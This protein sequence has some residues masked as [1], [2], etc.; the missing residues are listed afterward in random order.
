MSSVAATKPPSFIEI[1]AGLL[2]GIDNK[3]ENG[4]LVTFFVSDR[5]DMC[6]AQ[7]HIAES[8][9]LDNVINQD[10]YGELKLDYDTTGEKRQ[11]LREFRNHVVGLQKIAFVLYPLSDTTLVPHPWVEMESDI[12][13]YIYPGVRGHV[14][15]R[16]KCRRAF[17]KV[18]GHKTLLLI[19]S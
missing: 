2:P 11:A 4:C 7:K 3:I 5:T 17:T 8:L 16:G 14:I 1:P 13:F 9:G 12:S 18:N 6:Y 10:G 15:Q 19:E